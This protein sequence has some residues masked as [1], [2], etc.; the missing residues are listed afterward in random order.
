MYINILTKDYAQSFLGGR[1]KANIFLWLS[2]GVKCVS[3]T[4]ENMLQVF[5]FMACYFAHG[6]NYQNRGHKINLR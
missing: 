1:M 2:C 3:L 5:V 6:Q 4:K